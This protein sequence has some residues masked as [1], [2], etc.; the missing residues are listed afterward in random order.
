VRQLFVQFV[1]ED[2]GQDLVEYAFL[3]IFLA[4]AVTLGVQT[5]GMNLDEGYSNIGTQVS[6]GS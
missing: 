6:S 3:A 4:L 5:I 1:R 2:G